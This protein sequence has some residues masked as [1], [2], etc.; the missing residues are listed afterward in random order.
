MQPQE[1]ILQVPESTR[2]L[3]ALSVS[4]N[5]PTT[6]DP[7]IRGLKLKI[8]TLGAEYSDFIQQPMTRLSGD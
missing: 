8:V 4:E 5:T 6:N 1:P 7:L 3:L 2:K